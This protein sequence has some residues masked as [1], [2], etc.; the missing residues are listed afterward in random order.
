M[1]SRA[2]GTIIAF[3]ALI[4]IGLVL[5]LL[6][7]IA[8]RHLYKVNQTQMKGLAVVARVFSILC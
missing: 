8:C 7:S 3:V 4:I 1:V 6:V 2:C 5:D